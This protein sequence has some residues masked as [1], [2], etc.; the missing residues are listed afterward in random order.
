MASGALD[1]RRSSSA[2]G[3]FLVDPE[4]LEAHLG[5]P[6][7][8]VV[9]VDVSPGPYAEGHIE[10]AVL[11]NV[12]HDLKDAEYGLIDEEAAVALI[13]R[14]G[15]APGSLVV[16]YGYAPAMGFWFL[17]LHGHADVRVLDCARTTWREE[18]RPWT[19]SV[20]TPEATRYPLIGRDQGIRADQPQVESA[21]GSP[22]CRLLDV[23]TGPEFRGERF[24][25]SGGLEEGGRPGHIPSAVH[26]PIGALHDGRGSFLP[27]A[28]LRRQ[29]S[30]I[31]LSGEDEIIT[32]CT[33]GGRAST[34][35]F[36]LTYLLDRDDVRVYDGSWAEWGRLAGTPVACG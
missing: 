1:T 29:F 15:I 17:K 5:D 27:A 14:S 3:E 31:D 11:W 25:P 10:G 7:L 19:D 23:R 36:V 30:S 9:E 21:I 34:V 13:G 12:Y 35:W 28:D 6:R 33:I 8:R 20:V 16:L 26:L 4:W 22:S 18:G 32:Y 2:T 24:W